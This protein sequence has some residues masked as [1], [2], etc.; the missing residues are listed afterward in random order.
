MCIGEVLKV[1]QVSFSFR[2]EI[3]DL[4]KSNWTFSFTDFA[5]SMSAVQEFLKNHQLVSNLAL[6]QCTSPFIKAKYLKKAIY[7]IKFS[8]CV[9]SAVKSHKFRWKK[10]KINKKLLPINFNVTSRPRRQDWDG[11]LLE[12]GMFYFT[13][14]FLLDKEQFQNEK[15]VLKIY[16]FTNSMK[17]FSCRIVKIPPRDSIEIDKPIDLH[18]ARLIDKLNVNRLRAKYRPKK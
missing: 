3:W 2:L 7:R 12:A 9:F 18:M 4:R 13:K 8:D 11:E 17:I 16:D 5:S 10:D 6:I 14:R 1:Q 15:W